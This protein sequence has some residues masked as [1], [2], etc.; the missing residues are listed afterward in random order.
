MQC[1][2]HYLLT[3]AATEFGKLIKNHIEKKIMKILWT[4]LEKTENLTVGNSFGED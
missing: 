3:M 1:Y 2:L 4:Y